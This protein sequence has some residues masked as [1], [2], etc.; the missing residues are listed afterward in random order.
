MYTNVSIPA[1][2]MPYMKILIIIL[3]II[4][5]V[6]I[7]KIANIILSIISIVMTLAIAG[8]VLLQNEG[9]LFI[10]KSSSDIPK[11][12]EIVENNIMNKANVIKEYTDKMREG[13]K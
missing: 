1:E 11:A 5:L 8:T 3:A 12:I 13:S 6:V 10:P 4:T 2:L 9:K 7:I